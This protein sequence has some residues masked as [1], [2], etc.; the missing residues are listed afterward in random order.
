MNDDMSIDQRPGGDRSDVHPALYRREAAVFHPS[1]LTTG[2]WRSDAQH[3]GPPSGLLT[4]L[5]EEQ[6]EPGERLARVHINLLAPIPVKP[7]ASQATT[8]RVSRRVT[9]IEAQLFH[10]GRRVAEARALALTGEPTPEPD[11]QP[12]ESPSP[13]WENVAATGVAHWGAG[14][15]RFF[16]RDGIEHRFVEGRF[17]QAGPAVDWVRL[18]QPVIDG[19]A[20][21]GFQRALTVVDLGSG[22]SAA[23]DPA[24]GFGMINADLN[25]AFVAEPVGSWLRLE[26]TTRVADTGLGMAMTRVYDRDGLVA[27]ATQSLIGTVFEPGL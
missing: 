6:L 21:T 1:E 20:L 13:G 19:V 24:K 27:H 22:I 26:A 14:E 12:V 25:V 17:E 11:W 2:P 9:H 23:F 16:H 8:S 3:G 7:L 5:C 15:G 18:R 4:A 10:Q